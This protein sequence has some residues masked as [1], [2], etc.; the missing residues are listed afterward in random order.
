MDTKLN[1][2]IPTINRKDL[3][4]ESLEI[5]DKQTDEF[6]QLLIIDNGDQKIQQDICN[7]KM[8]VDNKVLIYIPKTN[9]GVA[10]SW[11]YG[12]QTFRDSDYILILND[13]ICLDE[14]Q[15]S[16]VKKFASETEFWLGT[17]AF[18]WSMIL[19]S[20]ECW[21]YFI[22]HEGN[23][24][25]PNFFPAYFEDNDFRHRLVRLDKAF[26]HRGDDSLTPAVK[27]N[28][29]TIKKDPKINGNFSANQ[30]YYVK[31]WGGTPGREKFKTAW[32]K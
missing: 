23:V 19:L 11:N 14:T 3:L 28:S 20:K 26:L 30:S 1:L 21:E 16:R 12:I 25:D 24:F 15:L 27:R 9:L 4:L 32:N 18:F 5:L 22:T 6:E 31:K 8:F 7:L 10:G 17:G 2:I 13:D 29:M